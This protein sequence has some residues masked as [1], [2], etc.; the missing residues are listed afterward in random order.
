LVQDLLMPVPVELGPA[1]SSLLSE[2]AGELHTLGFIVE[3]FGN[4]TF[5]IKA[6]PALLVGADY[7]KLLLDVLD[8]VNVHGRRARMDE[9]RDEL[10][11]VMACHPAIKV[12]RR[13]DRREM[14]ALLCGLFDCRMPHTCPHGRPTMIRFSL[15]ELRKMFKRT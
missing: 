15:D 8:E 13:L 3:D 11:S 12:N 14:E 10:L 7:R 1:Q 9:V 5:M 4:G 2:Y 6:V